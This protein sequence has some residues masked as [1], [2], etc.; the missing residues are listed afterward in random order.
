[1]RTAPVPTGVLSSVQT[2]T[3]GPVQ[4]CRPSNS[5]R[6][7]LHRQPRFYRMPVYAVLV[8]CLDAL[9]LSAPPVGVECHRVSLERI[10]EGAA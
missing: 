10:T 7:K 4:V 3:S 1:M 2:G 6:R 8:P 5:Q 9:P